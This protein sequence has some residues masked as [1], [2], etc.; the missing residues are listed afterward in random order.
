MKDLLSFLALF[1]A[2]WA[3]K[4]IRINGGN[5]KKNIGDKIFIVV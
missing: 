5:T 4:F 3:S 1:I 2:R